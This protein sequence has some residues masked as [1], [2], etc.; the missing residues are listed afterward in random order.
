MRCLNCQAEMVN[1]DVITR[2]RS[3]HTTFVKSAAV[4]GLIG[5]SS[6]RW[7]SKSR[8]ASNFPPKVGQA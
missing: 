8:G 3:F 5:E 4:F 1:Y 2:K 7:R 6:I